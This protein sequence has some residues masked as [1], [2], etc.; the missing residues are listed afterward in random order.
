MKG[1]VYMSFFG[2]SPVSC[3]AQAMALA[4]VTALSQCQWS[5]SKVNVCREAITK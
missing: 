1:D 4:D 3:Y 2:L 5:G